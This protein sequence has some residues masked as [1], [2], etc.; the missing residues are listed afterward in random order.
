MK[1]EDQLLSTTTIREQTKN[2]QFCILIKLKSQKHQDLMR[3]L[4]SISIDHSTLFLN[5]QWTELQSALEPIILLSR[6]GETMFQHSNSILMKSA[7]L[8]DLNNGRTMLL[9]FN[10]TADQTTS[11]LHQVSLQDGGSCLNFKDNSLSMKE[12]RFSMFKVEM[13][14]KTQMWL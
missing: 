1:R 4:D 12:A 5:S 14:L 11:E 3:N 9:K 2:G 8:S 6:D 10:P 7:R 13:M